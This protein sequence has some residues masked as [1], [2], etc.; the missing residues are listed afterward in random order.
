MTLSVLVK[1]AVHSAGD[2]VLVQASDLPP[3]APPA[4]LAA[5]LEAPVKVHSDGALVQHCSTDV[6]DGRLRILPR[7]VPEPSRNPTSR[8]EGSLSVPRVG[9]SQEAP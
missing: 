1:A 8:P 7:V 2:S 5:L 3:V 6:L 4:P 9:F